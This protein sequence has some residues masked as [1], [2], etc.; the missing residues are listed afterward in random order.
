MLLDGDFEEIDPSELPGTPTLPITDIYLSS[1]NAQNF[2]VPAGY[3]RIY[4]NLNEGTGGRH[5]YLNYKRGGPQQPITDIKVVSGDSPDVDPG[6][7]WTRI[8]QDT[9]EGAKGK[10]VYICIRRDPDQPP[11]QDLQVVIT[12]SEK[13]H[14]PEG[15]VA[16]PGDLNEDAGNY[17]LLVRVGLI[18]LFGTPQQHKIFLVYRRPPGQQA[19]ADTQSLQIN[20]N[21]I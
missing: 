2:Q 3:V 9:N 12:Q 21:Q 11:I 7:G 4:R 1:H 14:T 13:V 8:E 18:A 6:V 15:F 20:P 5:I 17:P 16:V 19:E 10:H